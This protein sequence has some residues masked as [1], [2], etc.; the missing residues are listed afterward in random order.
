[1]ALEEP[2]AIGRTHA[3]VVAED[4]F[5]SAEFRR[6]LERLSFSEHIARELIR[7]RMHRKLTQAALARRVGTTASVISRLERG[8]HTPN[9]E[10]LR[11]IAEATGST[12]VLQ[13]KPRRSTLDRALGRALRPTRANATGP[14]SADS[15]Q[16][17]QAPHRVATHA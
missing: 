2:S 4:A 6:E 12:L 5:E 8:D 3:E 11:K 15:T 17:R 10:T 13:F 7:L 1:M 9:I 16:S 14:S